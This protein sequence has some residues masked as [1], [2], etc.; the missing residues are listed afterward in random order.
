[1]TP[2]TLTLI[3]FFRNS[4]RRRKL[5]S[6]L[7]IG[8]LFVVGAPARA[9][10]QCATPGSCNFTVQVIQNN[11]IADGIQSDLVRITVTD[12]VTGLPVP[13]L[14]ISMK[15]GS[16]TA[17]I[18]G[19]TGPGGIVVFPVQNTAVGTV[20]LR[21]YVNTGTPPY[22][23]NNATTTV[24]FIAGPPDASTSYL[25]V[26]HS[27][28]TA[29]GTSEDVVRA[30]LF[31]KMGN[32]VTAAT[33]VNFDVQ[34]GTAIFTGPASSGSGTAAGGTIDAKLVSTVVGDVVVHAAATG[35]FGT[36]NITN[37]VTVKFIAGPPDLQKSY[38]EVI[39]S[40][41][42][43][44]GGSEDIV[45]AH[46]FDANGHPLSD[47]AVQFAVTS[48]TASFNSPSS[49]V[50]VGG[51][52]D[53]KLVSLTVGSVNV[54]AKVLING[55]WQPISNGAG[56][57]EV[58]VKFVVGPP[59][60][61]K[62]DFQLVLDVT[63]APADG[64]SP[65]KIHA[66]LV[67]KSGQVI[68][69]PVDISF[70][71]V[72]GG[73]AN[74]TAMLSGGGT[75]ITPVNGDVPLTITNLQTGTVTI[76][77]TVTYLGITYTI[78]NG[79]P[80]TVTFIKP[81]PDATKSNTTLVVDIP[82]ADADG[83]MTTQI[84]AHLVNLGGAIVP[85]WEVEFFIIPSGGPEATAIVSPSSYKATSDAA[86]N[87]YIT[88]ANTD[89]GKVQFG[90]KYKDNN[91]VYHTITF[92]SPATVEFVA[93]PAV[94]SAPGTKTGLQTKLSIVNDFA[95][96][97]DKTTNR[98]LALITDKDGHPK[99]GVTVTFSIRTG[100][101]STATAKFVGTVTVTTQNGGKAY[102]DLTNTV[103]GTV[104][105]DASIDYNG[106][107][108]TLID[109]SYKE[110]TFTNFPDLDNDQTR[111]IVVVYEALADGQSM[112]TVKAHVVDLD[113]QP[114]S[115]WYVHFKIQS[116]NG[117]FVGDDS[118]QLVNGEAIINL[119]STKPG[120]VL[121]TAYLKNGDIKFGSPAKVKFAAINIYVPK[122]FTPNGDGSND[123]LKP[124]LVGIS[125]FHYF[126]VYNRWGNLI[127]TTQDPNYGWDG[128]F[129]G[130]PQPVETYLWIA[131]G[132]DV[133]GRKIVAK[134]M[135]SLV[136]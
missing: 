3:K 106:N 4:G 44:D 47:T 83:V 5:L 8:F 22:L 117:T 16:G 17:T 26:I 33:T 120:D 43:A 116:G 80:A 86:G 113:G 136:K 37:T 110:V 40:P 85:N 59:D 135:T 96:A 122:V 34:S 15:L 107:P 55:V 24:N 25:E 74:A 1:M 131:E 38:I 29:N 91:G 68:D 111:L 71:T 88:I 99:D 101:T 134:G 100:G 63:T 36:I 53:A 89:V 133:N 18:P 115:G 129:K 132:V 49:G 105:I 14:S 79:S 19:S 46:L 41:E 67:G 10:A 104:W 98:L 84:H 126:N 66:H 32:P 114:L 39:H 12:N 124:I 65:A 30:H 75:G 103:P 76:G 57:T 45:K 125:T 123:V 61:S 82:Q 121:V 27:P 70:F 54:V 50:T 97:D 56:G 127:F 95:P 77:C 13:S 112:T 60:V 58:T 9:A 20:D 21:F 62:P 93:G 7:V 64:V 73:T 23:I 42:T 72:P 52:M 48:G 130:V 6:A 102:I 2:T 51:A 87:A 69:Y 28:E 31:D 109:G 92:G 11:Q 90:A 118:V 35:A 108:S 81:E 94:P 78:V 128:R 119:T